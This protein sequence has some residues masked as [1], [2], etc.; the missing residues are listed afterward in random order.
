[1][2][3]QA[4]KVKEEEQ[5][6]PFVEDFVEEVPEALPAAPEEE[7]TTIEQMRKLIADWEKATTEKARGLLDMPE[8]PPQ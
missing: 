5:E 7:P 6:E 4:A 2:Q 1:M 8:A 3:K